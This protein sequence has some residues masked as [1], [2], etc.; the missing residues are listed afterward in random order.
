MRM[1][2]PRGQRSDDGGLTWTAA[3]ASGRLEYSV[4]QYSYTAT[5]NGYR[6]VATFDLTIGG[7]VYSTSATNIDV[8]DCNKFVTFSSDYAFSTNEHT[9]GSC[10]GVVRL[11]HVSRDIW[12]AD[13]TTNG[14]YTCT[15]ESF[16]IADP[17]HGA[18]VCQC[19]TTIGTALNVKKSSPASL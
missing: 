12:S 13:Q 18:K 10:Y 9:D 11:G 19:K 16:G 1:N 17:V 14:A 4:S 8:L 15:K 6:Q 7:T 3:L 2:V 5:T